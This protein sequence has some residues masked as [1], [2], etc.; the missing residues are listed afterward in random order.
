MAIR[1]KGKKID[2]SS[3]SVITDHRLFHVGTK[4]K[5]TFSN[6]AKKSGNSAPEGRA[7]A[8][9]SLQVSISQHG[10]SKSAASSSPDMWDC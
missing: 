3:K 1:G 6:K 2:S 7:P 10:R 8:L 5:K 4:K 9:E